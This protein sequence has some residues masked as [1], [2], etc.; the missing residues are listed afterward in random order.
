MQE[1][2]FMKFAFS[3][4][5][6]PALKHKRNKNAVLKLARPIGGKWGFTLTALWDR[7]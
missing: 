5:Y 2:G 7:H 1:A 4:S 6:F 3:H